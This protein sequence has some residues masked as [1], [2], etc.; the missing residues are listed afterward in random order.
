LCGIAS[1]GIHGCL[2]CHGDPAGKHCNAFVVDF[3][4]FE[5]DFIAFLVDFTAFGADFTASDTMLKAVEQP[6]C[7]MKILV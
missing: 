1:S 3:M 7:Q 6:S 5:V 4:A 2:S